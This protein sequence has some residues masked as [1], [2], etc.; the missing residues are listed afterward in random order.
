M[1]KREYRVVEVAWGDS[2]NLNGSYAPGGWISITR[3]NLD[4]KEWP[5][6]RSEYRATDERI[7]RLTSALRRV[8]FTPSTMILLCGGGLAV[9]YDGIRET[10]DETE[11]ETS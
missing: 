9:A 3:R 10:E 5:F 2:S 6:R 11:G 8:K 1:T 4:S 7:N